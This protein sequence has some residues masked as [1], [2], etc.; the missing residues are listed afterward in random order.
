M[1]RIPCKI[2][3]R[4]GVSICGRE[5]CAMRRKPY[6]PGEHGRGSRHSRRSSS[7]FGA[8]LREKQKL[9]FLYGLRE[10]QFRNYVVE[11]SQRTGSTSEILYQLLESRLD[12]V[13]YRLGFAFSRARARQIVTHGH[14]WV[15]GRSVN[16][17]SFRTRKGDIISIR[18]Q[19]AGKGLFKDLDIQLKK[20]NAPAWI[21]LDR[22]K[23]EGK[24]LGASAIE[25]EGALELNV[26]AI[27]EFYSR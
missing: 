19:S 5:K 24:V 20:Y 6:P 10:T 17:P 22:E 14:I 23:R 3:R 27:V 18:P 4:L 8:Q 21:E 25:L 1:A 7:E 13:V 2:C 16:I 9:K 12:N 11:A 15:N 26:N